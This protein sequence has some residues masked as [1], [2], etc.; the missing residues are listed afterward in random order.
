MDDFV[1]K[2]VSERQLHYVLEGV[3]Q[4]LEAG[5][6][7][8]TATQPWQDTAHQG[9]S[10]P[11]SSAAGQ[12]N[13]LAMSEQAENLM[14]RVMTVFVSAIP[15]RIAQM[16]AAWE[17]RDMAALASLFD[18]ISGSAEVVGMDEMHDFA[19]HLHRVAARADTSALER[20]Y[21]RLR[22][23]LTSIQECFEG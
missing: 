19:A 22:G 20:E 23:A 11:G 14:E 5:Q 9:W 17:S 18:S 12:T 8:G 2:P 15:E 7:P 16:D 6:G 10:E 1:T 21:P 4:A 13:G 3:I